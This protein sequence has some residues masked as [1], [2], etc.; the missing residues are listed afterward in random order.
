MQSNRTL[1]SVLKLNFNASNIAKAD[2]DIVPGPYN[3][4]LNRQDHYLDLQLQ[5]ATRLARS[6]TQMFF[7]IGTKIL[8]F[9]EYLE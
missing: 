4:K 1:N 5:N 9:K 3:E 8:N 2:F 6:S 7:I